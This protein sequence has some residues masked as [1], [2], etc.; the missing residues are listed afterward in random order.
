LQPAWA[1][2]GIE[3][4]SAAAARIETRLRMGKGE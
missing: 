4:Q 1:G 3:H 2:T